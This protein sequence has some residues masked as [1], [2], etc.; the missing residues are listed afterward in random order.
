MYTDPTSAARTYSQLW[1]PELDTD[2]AGSTT[3]AATNNNAAATVKTVPG[4]SRNAR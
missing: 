4:S 3:I 1:A 2:P